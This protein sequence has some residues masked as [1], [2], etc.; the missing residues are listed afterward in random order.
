M[1]TIQVAGKSFMI[2]G[3]TPSVPA[4]FS[5]FSFF[6]CALT[7]NSV[8]GSSSIGTCVFELISSNEV[9]SSELKTWSKK[10]LNSSSVGRFARVADI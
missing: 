5:L 10:T 4:A 1:K 2:P 3:G 7:S 9:G 6:T 8:M